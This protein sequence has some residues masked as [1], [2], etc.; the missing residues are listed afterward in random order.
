MW[1]TFGERVVYEDPEIRLGQADVGL[2]S[3]ERVWL[4]VLRVPRYAAAA[5]VNAE[6]RVLMVRRHRFVQDRW[7]WELPGG[8]ADSDEDL[9]DAAARELEDQAGYRAAGLEFLVSIQAVAELADAERVVFTGRDAMRVGD[10]VSSPGAIK[11]VEWVPLESVSGL[12][13]DGQIWESASVVGLLA[14]LT[15]ER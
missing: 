14:L 11:R 12:V 15:L 10:P 2:P 8:A 1:R 4:P 7:G 6:G 13:A 3:G 9:A 5:V